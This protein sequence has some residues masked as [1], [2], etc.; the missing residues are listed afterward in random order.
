M[1]PHHQKYLRD[2]LLRGVWNC[3]TPRF[4][5]SAP[6]FS[7][8]QVQLQG[9]KVELWEHLKRCS[10][11]SRFF[12]KLLYGRVCEVD[13]WSSPNSLKNA[14]ESGMKLLR[15][16]CDSFVIW[17]SNRHVLTRHLLPKNKTS[18]KQVRHKLKL[19]VSKTTAC[20]HYNF[21]STVDPGFSKCVGNREMPFHGYFNSWRQ[22]E[23]DGMLCSCL[24]QKTYN[25]STTY[26]L[27]ICVFIA[28]I[29]Q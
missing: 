8:K 20:V 24:N 16:K 9:K 22:V 5:S 17:I 14:D 23:G 4:F 18:I 11:N 13:L 29:S 26:I 2:C 15:P 27:N 28:Y 21:C 7:V 12:L 3:F 6:C 10:I 1:V 19:L 25:F